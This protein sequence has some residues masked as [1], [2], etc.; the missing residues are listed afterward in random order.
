MCGVVVKASGVA[1][2]PERMYTCSRSDLIEYVDRKSG[3]THFICGND[4]YGN[5]KHK[6]GKGDKV[7]IAN[8]ESIVLAPNGKLHTADARQQVRTARL[9][10]WCGRR[11]PVQHAAGPVSRLLTAA[12]WWRTP[13]TIASD[14]ST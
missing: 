2:T 7:T 10:G 13:T 12:C 4:Q 14:A 8:P 5:V 9:Q 1:V 3:D 11:G 6:D